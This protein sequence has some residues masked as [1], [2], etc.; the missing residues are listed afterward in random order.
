L[1]SIFIVVVASSRNQ[2]SDYATDKSTNYGSSQKSACKTIAL[3]HLYCSA[4]DF[5]NATFLKISG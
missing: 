5:L 3:T 4:L 2:G 1:L